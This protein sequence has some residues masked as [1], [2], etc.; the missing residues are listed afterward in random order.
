M[1]DC[2]A[3][4]LSTTF[5]SMHSLL[6]RSSDCSLLSLAI[7]AYHCGVLQC[8]RT[9]SKNDPAAGGRR[10]WPKIGYRLFSSR[11]KLTRNAEQANSTYTANS[12]LAIFT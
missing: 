12:R 1:T 8:G 9:V 11:N 2:A 7:M 4:E 6:A 5:I 3:Q 10:I